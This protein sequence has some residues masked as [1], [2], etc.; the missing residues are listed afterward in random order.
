M[1][2]ISLRL[3]FYVPCRFIL[4][5]FEPR[6]SISCIRDRSSCTSGPDAPSKSQRSGALR[7]QEMFGLTLPL[8]YRWSW[9]V[10]ATCLLKF[11]QSCALMLIVLL[12]FIAI[13]MCAVQF[14][15]LWSSLHKR[16]VGRQTCV[17][18]LAR[19]APLQ[20]QSRQIIFRLYYRSSHL[21]FAC[22]FGTT[23]WGFH[24]PKRRVYLPQ[25]GCQPSCR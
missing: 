17:R 5:T 9:S 1:L 3:S 14:F 19:N 11:Q 18:S 16:L 8:V 6:Q 25:R 12:G 15:F 23:A 10:V 24:F 2:L 13:Y 22:P 20:W 7:D 21:F 4:F